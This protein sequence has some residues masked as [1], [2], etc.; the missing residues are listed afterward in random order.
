MKVNWICD[1]ICSAKAMPYKEAQFVTL[2]NDARIDIPA[3]VSLSRNTSCFP[4]IE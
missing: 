2:T 4:I 1:A 3:F